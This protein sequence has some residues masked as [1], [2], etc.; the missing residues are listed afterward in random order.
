MT[1]V[2]G[3]LS[4]VTVSPITPSIA[5]GV[6]VQAAIFRIAANGGFLRHPAGV[7]QILTVLSGSGEVAGGDGHFE[8]VGEGDAVFWAAG[9]EHET[10]SVSGMTVLIVEGTGVVPFVSDQR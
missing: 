1:P 9:E 8:S 10:K 2:D 5:S 6:P 3:L 4:R 7:P